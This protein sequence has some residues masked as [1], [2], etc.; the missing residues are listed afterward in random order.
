MRKLAGG[1]LPPRAALLAG[2]VYALNP[3]FVV[4][5]YTRCAYAELLAS[6]IFPLL[7][8]GALRI[9]LEPRKSTVVVAASLGAIWLTSLPAGVIATYSLAC[10]LL[11]LAFVHRSI[12][13]V[14]Y[15]A[16]ATLAGIG[17]AAFSLLPAAW[18]QKWVNIR[19]ITNANLSTAT[20]FLFSPF[21]LP[22]T[23]E[24]NRRISLVAVLVI[25]TAIVSAVAAR[26][27]RERF[28]AVWWTLAI[29]CGLSG[30][31][32]FRVSSPVWRTLPEL[33]FLQF[34]WRWMFPLCAATVLLLAFAACES[35]RR[36]IL[37]PAIALIILVL[38]AG[39]MH[40]KEWFPQVTGKIADKFQSGAGYPGLPEYS[41]LDERQPLPTN[42][43]LISLADP[44]AVANSVHVEAWFPEKKVI[45][46]ELPRPTAI[47]L[48][49]LAYP[50]WQA[51]VNGK[52][53]AL[54]E[55]PQTGQ[56]MASL[57]AGSSR[58]EISFGRT[59]DRAIGLLISVASCTILLVF[60][61]F[62]ATRRKRS[63]ES[64]SVEVAPAEA[65]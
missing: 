54:R 42:A 15:G 25:L 43:P 29:L 16:A 49:L 33:R 13:P 34:P 22:H 10:A 9:E 18:E 5:A 36:P 62:F 47:N 23:H 38:D 55:N 21:G 28:A 8:W 51:S 53:L 14:L 3:Y 65:A 30:F 41:P 24:F 12:R 31:L 57:P 39:T 17:I 52:P 6:A 64:Q 46:A 2:L 60:S 27:N 19:A 7:L 50:A 44:A 11:V 45:V 48:K 1:W 59:W 32:M 63:V 61:R 40:T 35:R 4:T 20:N 56:L 58:T 26:R 37:W